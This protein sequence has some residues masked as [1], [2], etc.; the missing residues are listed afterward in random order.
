M[1]LTRITSRVLAN[2]AV[3]QSKIDSSVQLGSSGGTIATSNTRPT[4]PNNGT[5]IWNSANNVLETYTGAGWVTL[6]SQTYSINGQ[7]K[8][9]KYEG[10]IE[11]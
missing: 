9:L 8:G 7:L 10:K 4:S 6:A 3:T 2:N 5:M 1:P 11:P